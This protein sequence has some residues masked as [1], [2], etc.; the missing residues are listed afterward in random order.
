MKQI[1]QL[2]LLATIGFLVFST[3]KAKPETR[4]PA[5]T[6]KCYATSSTDMVCRR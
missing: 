1:I 2:I 4:E 6:V 3:S 5:T